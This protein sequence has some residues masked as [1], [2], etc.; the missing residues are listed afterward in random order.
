MP[1]RCCTSKDLYPGT[2]SLKYLML[3]THLHTIENGRLESG[4]VRELRPLNISGALL[5]FDLADA[6]WAAIDLD[7]AEE[8]YTATPRHKVYTPAVHRTPPSLR[9][10]VL[11]DV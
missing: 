3:H 2:T 4:K 6:R 5:E 7:F 1:Q 9:S 11:A 10:S 8:A